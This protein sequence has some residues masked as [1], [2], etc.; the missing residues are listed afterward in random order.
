MPA[1]DV[2]TVRVDP[3]VKRSLE[4]IAKA[5]D[6]DRSSVVNRALAAYVDLYQWQIDHVNEGLRQADAGEF[7]P[8]AE[9]DAFFTQMKKRK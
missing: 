7:V 6:E 1:R 5:T 2:M 9:V 8:H 3:K 4:K